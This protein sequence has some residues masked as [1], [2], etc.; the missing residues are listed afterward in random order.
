MTSNAPIITTINNMDQQECVVC[1]RQA[2]LF[3]ENCAEIQDTGRPLNARWYCTALCRESDRPG[4][5]PNCFS[6][7]D[8][9]Q[10][11]HS[12]HRAGELAQTLFYVFIEHTWAYDISNLLAISDQHGQISA[13]DVV[14]GPGHEA[15]PGGEST[16]EQRAGGWLTNFPQDAFK[17]ADRKAK[18]T[19]LADQHSVW[20]FIFMHSVVQAVFEGTQLSHVTSSTTYNAS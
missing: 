18:H 7:A 10:I 11:L 9:E 16:C 3:C 5:A 12:A 13:L 14:H 19:L 6:Q 4:H 1:T 2:W 20:A 15:G 8:H 17:A